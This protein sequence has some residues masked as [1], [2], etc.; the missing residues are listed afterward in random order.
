[1]CPILGMNRGGCIDEMLSAWIEKHT[2]SVVRG[3]LCLDE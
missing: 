1:M 2:L 3:V